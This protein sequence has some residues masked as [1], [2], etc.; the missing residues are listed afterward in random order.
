[1]TRQTSNVERIVDWLVSHSGLE[2]PELD[3]PSVP[4]PMP[5]AQATTVT[6]PIPEPDGEDSDSTCSDLTD[7]LDT[8]E[9]TPLS[10]GM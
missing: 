8:D 3:V 10:T 6:D 2:A 7:D 9:A 5:Q 1:M 4:E